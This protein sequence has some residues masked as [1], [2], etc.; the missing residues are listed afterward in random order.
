MNAIDLSWWQVIVLSVV[1]GIT[2]FLP[3]SSSAHL[4]L[5][6]QFLGW[7]DQ[8]LAFDVAVHLG[9]M[10]AVVLFFRRDLYS[11]SIAW[12]QSII[13]RH[14]SA[15]SQLVWFI[16]L[17][18]LPAVAIGFA[19]HD[20]VASELRT[21]SV[22]GL[23]NVVFALLLY[24]ADRFGGRVRDIQQMTV[25]SALFI[26]FMQ[27]LAL[28]PGTSRAGIVMTAA[29]L[30]GFTRSASTRCA[31]L[32]SIPIIG[33]ASALNLVKLIQSSAPT[34]WIMI[35]L[36]MLLTAIIAYVCIH[37]LLCWVEKIGMLPFVCYRLLL[38]L[39][40]LWP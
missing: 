40:L 4:I 38:G 5:V 31:L 21:M 30:L 23:A 18:T 25:Y 33:A 22:I 14:Q 27:A 19:V 6:G 17:A 13:Q 2:E 7:N 11:M 37:L 10:I 24:G 36:A 20:W 29:L 32:L 12:G 28:I 8:G 39:V 35:A 15:Q 3:I 9:T 1:Q 16:M 34:P 26:G